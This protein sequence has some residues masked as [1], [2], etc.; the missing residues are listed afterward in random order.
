MAQ[1]EYDLSFV[2]NTS[3]RLSQWYFRVFLPIAILVILLESA[4]NREWHSTYIWWK[5]TLTIPDTH[6]F[7]NFEVPMT[8]SHQSEE[9]EQANAEKSRR[10]FKR[11]KDAEAT[12]DPKKVRE[13]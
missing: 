8:A 13:A 11:I 7:L 2:G 3:K 1:L 6:D 5:Q 12:G 9:G 10:K 4:T